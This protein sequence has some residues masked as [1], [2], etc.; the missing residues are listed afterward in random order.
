VQLVSAFRE[1]SQI[2]AR[3]DDRAEAVFAGHRAKVILSGITDPETLALL[4]HLL[5]DETIRQLATPAALARAAK[6]PGG[7][8]DAARSAPRSRGASPAEALG[9][10]SPGNGVLLYGHIPPAPITLRPWFRDR[11]LQAMV[12][13]ADA[14][15]ARRRAAR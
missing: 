8:G 11:E 14:G 2:R 5:G 7:K 1:L 13:P 15:T 3:Y 9:W 6:D 12:S 10:I 4:S